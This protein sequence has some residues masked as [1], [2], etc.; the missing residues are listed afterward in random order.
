VVL[1]GL[2]GVLLVLT[3]LVLQITVGSK[4]SVVITAIEPPQAT[5]TIVEID[6]TRIGAGVIEDVRAGI[7]TLRVSASG[8]ATATRQLRV[9]G[10]AVT[11]VSPIQLTPE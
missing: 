10:R 2:V 1:A 11:E 9:R 3:F 6:R 5:A 4:G 8:H 7:Y